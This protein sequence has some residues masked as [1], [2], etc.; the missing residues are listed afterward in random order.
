[1]HAGVAHSYG[2]P[3]V[4]CIAAATARQHWQFRRHMGSA[5]ASDRQYVM[6]YPQGST[7]AP[8]M[9][10][11]MPGGMDSLTANRSEWRKQ[12]QHGPGR[13]SPARQPQSVALAVEQ[14]PRA[15]QQQQ[16]QQLHKSSAFSKHQPAR[17][18]GM[19]RSRAQAAT[20]HHT[21]GY[22]HSRQ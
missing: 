20:R 18:S 3:T 6:G 10:N 2:A 7:A 17:T 9:Q 13:S 15:Q 12:Q 19:T 14:P 8:G 1:M 21:S 16:L 5:T 4:P 22:A 11:A